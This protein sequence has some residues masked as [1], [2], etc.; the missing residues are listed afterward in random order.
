M[1]I[2]VHI[3]I[4]MTH[5][6]TIYIFFLKKIYIFFCPRYKLPV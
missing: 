6:L 5:L 1:C 4:L 2:N 3:N